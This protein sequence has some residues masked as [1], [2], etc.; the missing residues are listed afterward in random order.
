MKKENMEVVKMESYDFHGFKGPTSDSP[1]LHTNY[2]RTERAT[3]GFVL[4]LRKCDNYHLIVPSSNENAIKDMTTGKFA[5]VVFGT[6][7]TTIVFDDLSSSPMVL[8]IG[9]Q[10]IFGVFNDVV[11]KPSRKGFL[12]IYKLGERGKDGT[13]TAKETGRMDLWISRTF[14]QTPYK[15]RYLTSEE[16]NQY[17]PK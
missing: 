5:H 3:K 9:N 16:L 1:L 15:I 7:R 8:Q 13:D 10:Q 2:F 4:L 14:E 11:D 12:A 17:Q 6:A